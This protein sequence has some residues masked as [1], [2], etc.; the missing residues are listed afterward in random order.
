MPRK[1]HMC[2]QAGAHKVEEFMSYYHRCT[3]EMWAMK[4]MVVGVFL[5]LGVDWS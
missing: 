5:L 1:I 2:D 4:F 3:M